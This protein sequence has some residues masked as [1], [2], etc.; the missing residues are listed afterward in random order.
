MAMMMA[1][2]KYQAMT[3]LR[4]LPA[5]HHEG[6]MPC[7]SMWDLQ[8]TKWQWGRLSSDYFR[9]PVSII[10]PLPHIHPSIHPFIHSSPTIH[11]NL[12]R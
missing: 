4:Q 1:E 12:S 10:P 9:F 3:L 5:S 2:Q 8:W 7:Q 6:L 11:N